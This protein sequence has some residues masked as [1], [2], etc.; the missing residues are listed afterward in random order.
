MKQD[1]YSNV[2]VSAESQLAKL[3]PKAYREKVLFY[4]SLQ[5]QSENLNLVIRY[6]K[7]NLTVFVLSL[8]DKCRWGLNSFGRY[9]C[10]PSST[11][12]RN[13]LPTSVSQFNLFEKIKSYY[14]SLFVKKGK[15]YRSV[16][17]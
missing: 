16:I 11:A 1:L 17:L 9:I 8:W 2:W 6:D 3:Y 13:G 7:T 10:T 4:L 15:R 5:S 12:L 14:K